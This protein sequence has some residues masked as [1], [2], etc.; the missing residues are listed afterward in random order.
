[1][2][3]QICGSITTPEMSKDKHF[4]NQGPI[5]VNIFF[6]TLFFFFFFPI[7]SPHGLFQIIREQGKNY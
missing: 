1:M 6:K 4:K 3:T 7:F 5:S 2:S